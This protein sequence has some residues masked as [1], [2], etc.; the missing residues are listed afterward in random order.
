MSVRDIIQSAG[1]ASGEKIY[2]EN[3]FSTYL[4]AG[5]NTARSIQNNIDL[6]GKG[7]AVWLKARS[8][9]SDHALHNGEN[10]DGRGVTQFFRTNDPN[11]WDTG[12]LSSFNSN[13]FSLS[14]S[15]FNVNGQTYTSWSF[16]KAPKFFDVVT[17]VGTGSARTVSHNLGSVPGCIIVKSSN[18]SSPWQVYHRSNGA[19]AYQE[20]NT[21]AARVTS[22]TDRW[23]NTSP[24]DTVFTV[25]TS[26]TVNQS[27]WTFTAYLFAHD[28]GGFGDSGTD[29]IISCGS[30]TGN[31]L[32]PAGPIIN[33]GWE[34]QFLLVK[35][36]DSTSNWMVID[37]MRSFAV[38]SYD[39]PNSYQGNDAL[40]Y[41]NTTAQE[42]YDLTSATRRIDPTPAGF[43]VTSSDA[44]VNASGG[45][46]IYIA[47][48]RGPMKTPTLGTEVYNS[49]Y[50]TTAGA[51]VV[52][53]GWP[54]DM[55]LGRLINTGYAPYLLLRLFNK[56]Y[57]LLG[58]ESSIAQFSN[59]ANYA[60]FDNNTSLST[61]ALD[62]ANGVY[63][64]ILSGFRRAPNFFD[65]ITWRGTGS[66]LTID[67]KLGQTPKI[68]ILKVAD[69]GGFEY[70]FFMDALTSGTLWSRNS[71]SWNFTK[72]TYISSMT[73]T[74]I[75]ITSSSA[76]N[77]SGATCMALLFGDCPG[78]SKIGTY[79]GTGTGSV[80]QINCGFS[81]GARFV[82]IRRTD[83]T[84]SW[85]YYDTN[86][87]IVSGNDPYFFYNETTAETTT[88]DWI[89]PYSPGFELSTA[90]GNAVNFSGSTYMYLAIS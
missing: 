80:N 21:T 77:Y 47:I 24:T 57:Y 25:G 29:N 27:G 87:G 41:A 72:S 63:P 55:A 37:D 15:A 19:G 6:G 82:M 4:Y 16:R 35:R 3:V 76:I 48:R 38:I 5:N 88:T 23:N 84:G 42:A 11:T 73:S 14:G 40:L 79:T 67:H 58:I 26:S 66:N 1:G 83:S 33:L 12:N 13:G 75:S 18:S 28:A 53:T 59:T 52:T 17:Y 50:K 54:V 39:S 86:R 45:T 36:A 22:N 64:T 44:S 20:L 56:G 51:A 68:A 31:A 32:A 43:R 46:Y 9:T 8:T 30:Y 70:Y 34:P 61:A 65:V 62:T 60:T 2:V 71:N 90:S 74:T 10:N 78:V 7:G 89:D 49:E 81:S 69:R 85:Y